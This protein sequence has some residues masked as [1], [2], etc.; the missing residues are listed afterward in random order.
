MS[1]FKNEISFCYK[2]I[3]IT[4]ILFA[5]HD[6]LNAQSDTLAIKTTIDLLFEGMESFDSTKVKSVLATDAFL[7]SI[8]KTKTGE[9]KIIHETAQEFVT[10][11]GIK[12]EG[13]RIDEILQSYE[14]KIDSDMAVAWTPYE[15]YINDIFSHCG[16][17]VFTLSKL[18]GTWQIMGIVDT[19]RKSD[20]EK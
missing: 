19:R 1:F 6:S 4:S 11:S 7:K 12:I 14:I 17:N 16:V 13:V 9:T 5:N 20:C 3:M 18:E 15:F 10:M 8:V 2:Y